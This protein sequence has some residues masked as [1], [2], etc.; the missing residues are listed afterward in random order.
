MKYVILIHSNPKPWGHP[1]DRFTDEG[2]A[3]PTAELDAADRAFDGLLAELSASGELVTGEALADP[4]SATVYRWR[5]GESL[6]SEG[7]FAETQEHVAG[8]F[9]IDCA[10]RER[11]EQI[12]T[13]FAGPGSV[14]ELRPAFVWE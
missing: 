14:A 7:P 10:T 6:A 12:A 1:T 3:V 5:S 2:R 11:A 4:A 8:F 9:L 13:Q